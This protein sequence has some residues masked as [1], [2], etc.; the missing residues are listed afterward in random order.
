[1]RR[2]LILCEGRLKEPALRELRDD[3]YRRCARTLSIEEREL[4]DLEALRSAIPERA[5]VVVLDERGKQLT[6]RELAGELRKLIELPASGPIVF[7]IGGADGLD[8]ALRGRATL[9][10]A[11]GRMTFAHRLVRLMLAEQLYR[12]VSILEGTPYHR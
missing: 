11:L 2:A 1:M 5:A 10:L 12:A 3:Y 7:V 6:S 8:D 4:R 9:L